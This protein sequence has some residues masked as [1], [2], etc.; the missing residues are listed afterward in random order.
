[1]STNGGAVDRPEAVIEL[2]V[3]VHR[4]EQLLENGLPKTRF[5][6]GVE[7]EVDRLPRAVFLGQ[8]SPRS[9]RL[10]DPKHPIEKLAAIS[11]WTPHLE[12]RGQKRL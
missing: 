5:P 4:D 3:L 1:M 8:I 11:T 9:S 2:L 6:P 10:Q 7:A 12:L